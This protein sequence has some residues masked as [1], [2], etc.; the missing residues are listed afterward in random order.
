MSEIHIAITNDDGIDSPGLRAAVEALVELGTVTIIAPTNQQTATGRGLTGNKQ[1]KL[2]R[3]PYR[4]GNTDVQAYHCPCSPAQVVRHAMFTLFRDKKPD[5][6]ISGINYGENL[7][8]MIG[9]SGTVGAALESSSHGVIALAVSKQT[10]I[11]SHHQYTDQDWQGAVYF[12]KEFTKRTL[13]K[14]LPTDIDVLK[15][16]V[17]DTATEN[18]GWETTRLSRSMYY[19]KHLDNPSV[20]SRIN[21]F[22]TRIQV[23]EEDLETD[24]D[25]Y[26]L[27][28]KKKV[29]VTPLSLDFTSRVDLG[30]LHKSLIA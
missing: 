7:G 1:S 10:D 16:D 4:V 20:D 6:L 26:V 14:Q 3:R 22:K 23:V 29:S 12:L 17:P 11:D 25:I 24:S 30:D 27:A 28:V 18:T 2:E 19:S 15:I 5:I 8:N 21:D 9:C 13:E